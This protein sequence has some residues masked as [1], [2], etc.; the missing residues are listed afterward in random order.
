MHGND[1]NPISLQYSGTKQLNVYY[2]ITKFFAKVIVNIRRLF[3]TF[4]FSTIIFNILLSLSLYPIMALLLLHGLKAND[5]FLGICFLVFFPF[6]FVTVACASSMA[7]V[8]QLL[9]I[10]VEDGIYSALSLQTS[11]MIYFIFSSLII[12]ITSLG[13]IFVVRPDTVWLEL[14]EGLMILNLDM[15]FFLGMIYFC[16]VSCEGNSGLVFRN[17][18]ILLTFCTLFGGLLIN[19]YK[20]PDFIKFILQVNPLFISAATNQYIFIDSCTLLYGDQNFCRSIMMTVFGYYPY[21]EPGLGNGIILGWGIFFNLLAWGVLIFQQSAT[22]VY[23]NNETTDDTAA[24]VNKLMSSMSLRTNSSKS[25]RSSHHHPAGGAGGSPDGRE[26]ESSTKSLKNI[27]SLPRMIQQKSQLNGLDAGAP[28]GGGGGGGN[29]TSAGD[30]GGGESESSTIRKKIGRAMSLPDN[31][32]HHYHPSASGYLVASQKDVEGDDAA[33]VLPSETLQLRKVQSMFSKSQP[34]IE[35]PSTS[36]LREWEL[37]AGVKSLPAKPLESNPRLNTLEKLRKENG[38]GSGSN[39]NS[40]SGLSLVETKQRS[41]YSHHLQ[42]GEGQG[43][44]DDLE[45]FLSDNEVIQ[46][47]HDEISDEEIQRRL[48]DVDSPRQKRR[49]SHHQKEGAEQ[50]D[51]HPHHSHSHGL[52]LGYAPL[53]PPHHPHPLPA[54]GQGEDHPPPHHDYPDPHRPHSRPQNSHE[55]GQQD[56]VEIGNRVIDPEIV[57]QKINNFNSRRASSS[58]HSG[59]QE[60]INSAPN[61]VPHSPRQLEPLPET[62]A[63]VATIEVAKQHQQQSKRTSHFFPEMDSKPEMLPSLLP[64]KSSGKLSSRRTSR[65]ETFSSKSSHGDSFEHLY[66]HHPPPSPSPRHAPPSSPSASAP[67]VRKNSLTSSNGSLPSSS[68]RRHHHHHH[69]HS[70]EHSKE[71]QGQGQDQGPVHGIEAK[72]SHITLR[73]QS[74]RKSSSRSLMSSQLSFREKKTSSQVIKSDPD[75]MV[76]F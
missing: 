71:E 13:A 25:L 14:Y 9:I 32:P 15:I 44:E 72:K 8:Y 69:H 41:C 36:P 58:E 31:P 66:N 28:A 16:V 22:G 3:L 76:A 24:M 35:E 29:D 23:I 47:D 5:L 49:R 6:M 38:T 50:R 74:S 18:T 59:S 43:D 52:D 54:H 46:V 1:Q 33:A 26:K 42:Q 75:D 51:S 39:S 62:E 57:R 67:V 68:P 48:G 10:D 65:T 30:T 21:S 53:H 2:L 12:C 27:S 37:A 55:Q 19:I 73:R 7:E 61:S 11:F 70:Q 64:R 45:K 63:T 20:F 40:S 17:V 34:P 60:H 56:L 4:N